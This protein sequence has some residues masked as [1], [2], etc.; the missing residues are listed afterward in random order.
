MMSIPTW[1]EEEGRPFLVNDERVLEVLESMGASASSSKQP[2]PRAG[3]VPPARTG[4]PAPRSTSSDSNP[5][6]HV[7]GGNANQGT[8]NKRQRVISTT[9]GRPVSKSRAVSSS[10]TEQDERGGLFH[11]APFGSRSGALNASLSSSSTT[12]T[13]MTMMSSLGLGLGYDVSGPMTATRTTIQKRTARTPSVSYANG[14]GGRSRAASTLPRPASAASRTRPTPTTTTA[15]ATPGT[16]LG[17]KPTGLGYGAT[18]STQKGRAV[19]ASAAVVNRSAG[20]VGSRA[21]GRAT[22]MNASHSKSGFGVNGRVAGV[23]KT[24]LVPARNTRRESFRPRPSVLDMPRY[25]G[26]GGGEMSEDDY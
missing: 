18:A 12:S 10:S 8:A 13:T 9:S 7:G 15:A 17:K 20:V 24:K 2:K 16:G 5:G 19:S 22:T 4:N 11:R 23:G 25:V 6:P 1:E 3:S 26:G 14:S 21:V